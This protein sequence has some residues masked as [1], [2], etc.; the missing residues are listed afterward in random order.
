MSNPVAHPSHYINANGVEIID[1]IDEMP[2]ARASAMKY[3]FR[4]GKKN[5]DKE[6]EDLQKAAW[7]IQRE[8]TKL[9][10]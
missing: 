6:L 3:I 10:K 8:I 5:P 2:F 1:L 4:A 9:T 7:L